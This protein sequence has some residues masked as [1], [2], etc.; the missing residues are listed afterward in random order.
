MLGAA[1]VDNTLKLVR[2]EVMLP[3]K[4]KDFNG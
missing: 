3:Q 1:K 2:I 4:R